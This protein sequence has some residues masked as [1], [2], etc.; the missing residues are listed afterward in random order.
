MHVK[1]LGSV[2]CSL[3]AQRENAPKMMQQRDL[4]QKGLESPGSTT[5]LMSPSFGM[6][7]VEYAKLLAW[8]VVWHRQVCENHRYIYK[9]VPEL[10]FCFADLNSC[11]EVMHFFPHSLVSTA[12]LSMH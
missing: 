7:S 8:H 4:Q 12:M 11:F 2:N 3:V 10:M 9:A 6:T 5:M 1:G